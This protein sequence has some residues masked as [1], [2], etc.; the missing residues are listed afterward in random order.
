MGHVKLKTNFRL[1]EGDQ[2]RLQLR[3]A[4]QTRVDLLADLTTYRW[5][6]SYQGRHMEG[7]DKVLAMIS[8]NTQMKDRI[9]T[10][11]HP[12]NEM[13][14]RPQEGSAH[15]PNQDCYGKSIQE[16]YTS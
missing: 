9:A 12:R 11:T 10:S 5:K 16:P 4:I 14:H 15:K 1:T 6:Y 2:T 3:K 7:R 13:H 8:I